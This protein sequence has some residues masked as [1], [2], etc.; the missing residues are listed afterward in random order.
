MDILYFEKA[1]NEGRAYYTHRIYGQTVY[2]LRL[3]SLNDLYHQADLASC[4]L[5]P[6]Y[7]ETTARELVET[8]IGCALEKATPEDREDN[9]AYFLLGEK[10]GWDTPLY[11]SAYGDQDWYAPSP[12][13]EIEAAIECITRCEDRIEI[14]EAE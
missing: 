10:Y 5:D 4:G 14:D 12:I 11:R 2:S 3:E 6:W 7:E 1:L 9:T 8:L 13:S